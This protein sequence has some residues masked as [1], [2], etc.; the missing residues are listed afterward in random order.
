MCVTPN[1][2]LSRY[3]NLLRRSR[4]PF[5]RSRVSLEKLPITVIECVATRCG[6]FSL[7]RDAHNK[8]GVRRR[9]EVRFCKRTRGSHFPGSTQKAQTTV[10]PSPGEIDCRTHQ[11]SALILPVSAS[12]VPVTSSLCHVSQWDPRPSWSGRSRVHL[13]VS[14]RSRPSLAS[15]L[16]PSSGCR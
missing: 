5:R 9:C 4:M 6:A 16:D 13:P 12:C 14:A 11:S 3:R 8:P 2:P 7:I 1:L 10:S 15:G